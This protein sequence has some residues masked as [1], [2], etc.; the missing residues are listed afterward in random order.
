MQLQRVR[1]ISYPDRTVVYHQSD[2]SKHA[3]LILGKNWVSNV[4]G[5]Q[6]AVDL[7][8]ESTSPEIAPDQAGLLIVLRKTISF[9]PKS[10]NINRHDL[11]SSSRAGAKQKRNLERLL[12]LEIPSGLG[13]V[14]LGVHAQPRCGDLWSSCRIPSAL[15]GLDNLVLAAPGDAL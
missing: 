8:N 14:F 2:I 9:I 6:A 3:G 5:R 7:G 15:A 10:Y 13:F 11:K 12:A 4:T 1:W